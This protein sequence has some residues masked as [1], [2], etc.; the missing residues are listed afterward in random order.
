MLR[1]SGVL[2]LFLVV[3]V[4]ISSGACRSAPEPA[5][6]P[7]QSAEATAPGDMIPRADELY[8]ERED[9]GKVREA[10]ALMRQLRASDYSNYEAAWRLAKFNYYLGD[11]TK[12]NEE[13][14]RAFRE[15]TEASQAAIRVSGDRPEGHFWLGANL[16]GQSKVSILSGLAYTEEIR[17]TMER[18]IELDPEFMSGSAYMALGQLEL[19]LPRLMGGEPRKAVEYLETGLKYGEGNSMLRLHL[20]RAYLAVNRRQEARKQFETIINMKDPDPTYL[21]EHKQASELARQLLEK[22]FLSG[23]GR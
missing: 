1:W 11:Q 21:P 15:G 3:P 18:V 23:S 2:A 10:L 13:R 12:D 9:L 4:T 6:E 14:D 17:R 7:G 20:G 5:E 22:E 16:G 19:E 8:T